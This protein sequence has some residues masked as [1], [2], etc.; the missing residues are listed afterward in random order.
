MRF[1]ASPLDFVLGRSVPRLHSIV[2]DRAVHYPHFCLVQRLH[3]IAVTMDAMQ[4]C[5]ANLKS[6]SFTGHELTAPLIDK[7]VSEPLKSNLVSI[8]LVG[9]RVTLEAAQSLLTCPSLRHLNLNGNPDIDDELFV[10]AQ[11][12]GGR[13]GHVYTTRSHGST[14]AMVNSTLPL[15]RSTRTKRKRATPASTDSSSEPHIYSNCADSCCAHLSLGVKE[16]PNGGCCPSRPFG[17]PSAS[18]HDLSAMSIDKLLSPS[19]LCT[20]DLIVS[21]WNEFEPSNKRSCYASRS[22]FLPFDPFLAQS[23]NAFQAHPGLTSLH[24]SGTNITNK[25]IEAMSK[26]YPGLKELDVSHCSNITDVT[27]I[28]LRC[29][30]LLSLNISGCPVQSHSDR[31]QSHIV[32]DDAGFVSYPFMQHLENLLFSGSGR[33]DTGFALWMRACGPTLLELRLANKTLPEDPIGQH[34]H[35]RNARAQL[36]AGLALSDDQTL[37]LPLFVRMLMLCERLEVL[38][39]HGMNVTTGAMKMLFEVARPAWT[40]TCMEFDVVNCDEVCLE[41]LSVVFGLSDL[42]LGPLPPPGAVMAGTWPALKTLRLSGG[43]HANSLSGPVLPSIGAFACPQLENLILNNPRACRPLL[44]PV[45]VAQILQRFPNLRSVEIWCLSSVAFS[46]AAIIPQ[47]CPSVLSILMCVT[48]G[49]GGNAGQHNI[50][51]E[52]HLP[53]RLQHAHQNGRPIEANAMAVLAAAESLSMPAL[54]N[55]EQVRSLQ[56]SHPNI[57]WKLWRH[58]VESARQFQHIRPIDGSTGQVVTSLRPEQPTNQLTVTVEPTGETD[59]ALPLRS[60]LIRASILVDGIP[61]WNC[62]KGASMH[63]LAQ[64]IWGLVTHNAGAIPLVEDW[65]CACNIEEFN[66]VLF[67]DDAEYVYWDVLE[68]GPQGQ[69]KF[70]K[71]QYVSAIAAA[72]QQQWHIFKRILPKEELVQQALLFTQQHA[73]HQKLLDDKMSYS[74]SSTTTST[75]SSPISTTSSNDLAMVSLE[76]N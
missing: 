53:A 42:V 76:S 41:T 32:T 6:V 1:R 66:G 5:E 62:E 64:S 39:I 73:W 45:Q 56:Q 54:L 25:T 27:P 48:G 30:Y 40:Q 68:P 67:Y 36:A 17:S 8:S 18:L 49:N 65:C 7:I 58:S 46:L 2:P 59:S 9:C 71:A 74:T 37:H 70:H 16:D 11:G 35:A 29:R 22:A 23:L 57:E 69:Y 26:L 52:H 4:K 34:I 24:L 19:A 28:L 43:K 33:L 51:A 10:P 60:R 20:S 13:R 38:D 31:L 3:Y 15:P 47:M 12:S 61:I 55:P 44:R 75:I 50:F 63:H 21:D 14:H 72:M